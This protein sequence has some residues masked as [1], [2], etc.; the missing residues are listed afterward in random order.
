[1][2]SETWTPGPYT[3]GKLGLEAV[4]Q[5]PII[6]SGLPE[7]IHAFRG[8]Y[9][10]DAK[11]RIAVQLRL[12][13]LMGCPVCASFFPPLARRIGLSPEAVESAF[14]GT[15]EGLTEKQFGAV[16]WAGELARGDGTE[17]TEIPE[18]VYQISQLMREQ[19][20]LQTRI[21]LLIHA[22]G[23]MFLPHRMIEN[24]FNGS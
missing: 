4:N 11:T 23:L 14:A 13:R 15:P 21:E 16:T 5:I 1:M 20:I 7:L 6:A 3:L 9:R 19:L 2:T 12:A 17:P 22:T 10:I 18:P 24:T 8:D